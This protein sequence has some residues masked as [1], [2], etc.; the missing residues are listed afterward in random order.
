ARNITVRQLAQQALTESEERHRV[1]MEASF[2]GIILSV[3]GIVTRANSGFCSM[4]G[5]EATEIIGQPWYEF[6][7]PESR[8]LV[9]DSF[10]LNRAESHELVGLRKD[11]TEFNLEVTGR[12]TRVDG[13]L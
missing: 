6:V 4:F 3:D 10:S 11:G 8:E 9:A 2:D 12:P 1:L 13:R 7:A 5:Y